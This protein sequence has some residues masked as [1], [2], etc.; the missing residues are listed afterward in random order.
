MPVSAVTVPRG[1]C[2]G[3]ET[4]PA[5]R[6]E[7]QAAPKRLR[8]QGTR[9]AKSPR[10]RVVVAWGRGWPFGGV[11]QLRVGRCAALPCA[12]CCHMNTWRGT[13]GHKHT[14]HARHA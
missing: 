9:E 6:Q 7:V 3:G 2:R 8:G 13:P 4:R 1:A 10:P 12:V 11:R 14:Q 5:A